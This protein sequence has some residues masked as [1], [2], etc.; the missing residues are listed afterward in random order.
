MN[1]LALTSLYPNPLQPHRAT[2]NRA[3]IRAL[4]AHHAV[5]VIAPVA[6][7][8]EIGCWW[9]SAGRLPANRQMRCDGVPV[10]HPRYWFPPRMLRQWYGHCFRHSVRP[11]F[12]RAV[13][14][15]GPDLVY[16]P[17]AYPD[18]WAAVSLGRRAGLPV[19]LKVHGSDIL[20]LPQYPAR[21][22]RTIE[23]LQQADAVIAVSHDLADRLLHFGVAA[24]RLHLV[25]DGV[26]S[27]LFHPG[28]KA[29]ARAR[30]GL[31]ENGRVVLAIGNLVAVKGFNILIESCVQL[32]RNGL[33]FVCYLIGGGPLR[34]ALEQ[35][36]RRC[37]LK[38]QVRFLGALPQNEL[39]D[40]YR[41]ADVFVLPSFSEGVPNV[42]LEAAS[43]GTPF[44]ASRVGG[45]PEIAHLGPSQLV[46]AGNPSQLALTLADTLTSAGKYCTRTD[47][48]PRTLAD[49]V[50]DLEV[51]FDAVM[52][53][54]IP[55]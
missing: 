13:A 36:V 49:V 35:Q 5:R 38:D 18:G 42:L 34:R 52:P 9:H 37:G 40:W 22:Q 14:E 39:P 8:D 48:R 30:L 29:Q 44:V 3:Q 12:E 31:E 54:A 55:A 50:T 43:C 41:A 11:A 27:A 2:F 26:D 47:I 25:Y 10:E 32:A 24:R 19:V 20:L 4:A 45:I 6:W 17:W 53:A 28:P 23:A 15:F 46:P 7:T 16:A 21:R 33:P 1:I 51:V